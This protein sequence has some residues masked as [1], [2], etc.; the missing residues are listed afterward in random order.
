MV[1]ETVRR[2]ATLAFSQGVTTPTSVPRNPARR[3]AGIACVA[4]LIMLTAWLGGRSLRADPLPPR[5]RMPAE[6]LREVTGATRLAPD[7]VRSTLVVYFHPSCGH[8]ERMLDSLEI[9]A[10]RLRG[11]SLVFATTDDSLFERPVLARWPALRREGRWAIVAADSFAAHF[12]TAITPT[13]F[14]FGPDGR[15]SVRFKGE[16]SVRRLLQSVHADGVP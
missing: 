1:C 12:G 9:A 7:G 5:A 2:G 15:L 10:S 14:A 4:T 11:I 6:P 13:F 16:T 3:I 8:C